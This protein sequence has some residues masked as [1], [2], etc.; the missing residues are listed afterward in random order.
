MCVQISFSYPRTPPDLTRPEF[1]RTRPGSPG[2]PASPPG[3]RAS[4]SLG[5]PLIHASRTG[6]GCSVISHPIPAPPFRVSPWLHCTDY[7]SRCQVH[8]VTVLYSVLCTLGS[9]TRF[10]R[11]SLSVALGP[12]PFF[13]PTPFSLRL[14]LYLGELLH[15]LSWFLVLPARSCG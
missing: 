1:P 11:G 8:S 12:T 2:S 9:P 5:V 4:S 6:A 14:P 7:T 3:A 10:V 13:S 15:S